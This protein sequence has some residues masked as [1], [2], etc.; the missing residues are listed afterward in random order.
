M[1]TK[2]PGYTVKDLF[3]YGGL[4]GGIIIVY[5]TL[6]P[7]KIHPLMRLLLGLGV[8]VA[9]GWLLERTYENMIASRRSP[10]DLDEPPRQ[11]F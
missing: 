4:F 11:D 6:D 1:A 9:L 7:W 10:D 2:G 8:G 5:T 3:Y